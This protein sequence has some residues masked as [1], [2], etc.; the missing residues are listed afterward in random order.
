MTV[1]GQAFN[2]FDIPFE[3][4]EDPQWDPLIQMRKYF[5][6]F[7][8]AHENICG[9]SYFTK[10]KFIFENEKSSMG[11]VRK[12]QL[13]KTTANIIF[14]FSGSKYFCGFF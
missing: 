14:F 1:F 6:I 9:P 10:R 7:E 8:L 4:V 3:R 5:Y 2:K 11:E 12:G 13:R